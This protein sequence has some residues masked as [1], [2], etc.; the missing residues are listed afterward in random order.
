[1]KTINCSLI[2][3]AI[4]PKHIKIVD[5]KFV[6]YKCGKEAEVA[7]GPVGNPAFFHKIK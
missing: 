5:E 4:H 2:C 7:L 6:C 1:M 3:W